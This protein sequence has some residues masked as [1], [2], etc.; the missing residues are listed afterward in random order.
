MLGTFIMPNV[1]FILEQ[2]GL[3]ISN[4][5]DFSLQF[6]FNHETSFLTPPP[7]SSKACVKAPK[8]KNDVKLAN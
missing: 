7:N 6:F 5:I 3:P 4:L 1:L 8:K 2:E